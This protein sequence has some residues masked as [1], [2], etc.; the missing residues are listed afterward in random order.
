MT[1]AQSFL[2]D[3]VEGALSGT[4][5]RHEI[6]KSLRSSE[7]A[8]L[9]T[10]SFFLE[11]ACSALIE[12]HWLILKNKRSD[13]NL[14]QTFLRLA[15]SR[16]LLP[17][18][19]LEPLS[20]DLTPLGLKAIASESRKVTSAMIAYFRE[21]NSEDYRALLRETIREMS[22]LCR[23]EENLNAADDRLPPSL[24]RAFDRLDEIL[25]LQFELDAGMSTNLKERLY[26]GAG[27]GVQT[28]YAQ[29]FSVLENLHL[30]PD[31]HIIDLGSGFG[32]FGLVAGLLREDV[33]FTGYEFVGH[34]VGSARAS[35]IR[36]GLEKR[37]R[38]YEQD[39][40]DANFEIP[41]ADV[42]YMY[43]PF[44]EETYK[45][46]LR[47]LLEIGRQRVV[48]VVT[49]G[50]AGEWFAKT[51]PLHEWKTPMKFDHGILWIF[52][53]IGPSFLRPTAFP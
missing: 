14:F 11:S 53:S 40:A 34:R 52:Q 38:F 16:E 50:H 17:I 3:V 25:T 39:L 37:I 13:Q 19:F 8:E 27:C 45:K 51:A 5:F 10:I 2:F 9:L 1:R 32:R 43:D 44:S 46:V 12:R 18:G 28:S 7:A 22:T 15:L 36:A 20:G 4:S 24:Y 42:Y 33:Q 23:F 41:A 49:K 31:A 48:R 47:R 21:A 6:L 26:E 29:I 30:A 35:S